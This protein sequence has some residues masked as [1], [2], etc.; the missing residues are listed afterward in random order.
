MKPTAF[1]INAAR[2]PVVDEAALVRA[3]T[4]GWIAGAGLDVYEGEPAMA[5]GLAELENAVLVPHIASAS[6]DTR[7]K[8]ASMAAENAI[9]FLRG[10]RAHHPVNPEVYDTEAYRARAGSRS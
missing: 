5:P 8:M 7:G 9:A 3:L 10:Q 2:G 1:L 4:E 6:T